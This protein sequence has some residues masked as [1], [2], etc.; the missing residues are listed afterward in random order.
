[1]IQNDFHKRIAVRRAII[2]PMLR[3]YQ[4]P[5]HARSDQKSQDAILDEYERQLSGFPESV[6]SAAWE[7]V[8]TDHHTWTW[9]HIKVIR[10]ACASKQPATGPAYMPTVRK[11]H[12]LDTAAGD[13]FLRTPKG[14]EAIKLDLALSAWL[15]AAEG[16]KPEDFEIRTAV[17]ARRTAIDSMANHPEPNSPLYASLEKWW[18]KREENNFALAD[19]FSQHSEAA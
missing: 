8:K 17:I 15:H 13:A 7:D 6:L 16:G 2:D 3:L 9:P 5:S 4:P 14:Q 19:R 1:M 18:R 12:T 11:Q 10:D